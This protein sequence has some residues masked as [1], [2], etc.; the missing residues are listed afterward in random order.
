M[1]LSARKVTKHTIYEGAKVWVKWRGRWQAGVVVKA[2][3]RQAAVK[4]LDDLRVVRERFDLLLYRKAGEE[5]PPPD[6]LL[7]GEEERA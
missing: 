6:L 2:A 3:R 1:S 5:N 7:K 4:L